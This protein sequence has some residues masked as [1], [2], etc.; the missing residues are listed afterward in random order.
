MLD[1]LR[2][3]KNVQNRRLT[4]SL[5]EGEYQSFESDWE[6]QWQI[7]KGLK[8]KSGELRRYGNKLHQAT[9]NDNKEE[10]FR[11]KG[12]KDKST[13]FRN[14]S[15]SHCED[16]LGILQEIVDAN[17]SLNMQFDRGLDFGHVSLVDAQ[18]SN[19]ARVVT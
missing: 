8:D 5:T 2:C 7:R 17:A 19:F 11:K 18:L 16:A 3:G 13:K 4:T 15:E 9:F 10:C 12:N 1:E 14:L 6:S